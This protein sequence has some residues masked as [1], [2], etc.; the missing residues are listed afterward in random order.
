MAGVH[1]TQGFTTKSRQ[2]VHGADCWPCLSANWPDDT[3]G[4]GCSLSR[5]A[6]EIR[7]C[8]LV[9][10]IHGIGNIRWA[11][12]GN[13]PLRSAEQASGPGTIGR[14]AQSR[15]SRA[16]SPVW[17]APLRR[18]E[19]EGSPQGRGAGSANRHTPG[20]P[21]PLIQDVKFRSCKQRCWNTQP[22]PNAWALTPR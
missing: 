12:H 5:N 20:W 11:V 15:P 14:D 21:S 8:R 9:A 19:C 3:H 1:L 17:P 4:V 7:C 2:N 18:S 6:H 16:G 13:A 10:R 22:S